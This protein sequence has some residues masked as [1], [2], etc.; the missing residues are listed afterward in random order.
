MNSQQSDR[1]NQDR[2]LGGGVLGVNWVRTNGHRG[3]QSNELFAAAVGVG[4][5]TPWKYLGG[6][7]PRQL[8]WGAC[9]VVQGIPTKIVALKTPNIRE[10]GELFWTI[11]QFCSGGTWKWFLTTLL[12]PSRGYILPTT[13]YREGVTCNTLQN[14]AM[15]LWRE[16][17]S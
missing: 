10:R 6:N 8:F 12:G 7:W 1:F 5:R 9:C 15:F 4:T 17:V 16:S 3:K 11:S 2:E 13:G 14:R